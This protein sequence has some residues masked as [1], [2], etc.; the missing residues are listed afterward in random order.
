MMRSLAILACTSHLKACESLFV[1][2][3]SG[4]EVDS[5]SGMYVPF[6]RVKPLEGM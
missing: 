6:R 4:V 2:S 5:H 3:S 1:S